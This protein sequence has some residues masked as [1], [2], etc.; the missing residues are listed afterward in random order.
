MSENK[1]PSQI[2]CLV[3]V[4]SYEAVS[5]LNV[6]YVWWIMDPSHNYLWLPLVL[7]SRLL[8]LVWF[9]SQFHVLLMFEISLS[10]SCTFHSDLINYFLTQLQVFH[11]LGFILLTNPAGIPLRIA[12]SIRLIVFN[13]NPF[14]RNISWFIIVD[15]QFEFKNLVSSSFHLFCVTLYHWL[16]GVVLLFYLLQYVLHHENDI[17]VSVPVSCH[18]FDLILSFLLLSILSIL[19]F[20]LRFTIKSSNYFLGS[21]NSGNW[22]NFFLL[23][24]PMTSLLCSLLFIS[25]FKIQLFLSS[26]LINE[27]FECI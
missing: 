25:I 3:I 22:M 10:L 15:L 21:T 13:L 20:F 18:T 19:L 14:W 12:L 5:L 9:S 24:I 1:T 11:L 4:L 23:F 27:D 17:W 6:K 7:F 16:D 2:L 26:T 8:F